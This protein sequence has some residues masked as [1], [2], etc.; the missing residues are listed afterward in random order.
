MQFIAMTPICLP[1]SPPPICYLTGKFISA[2]NLNHL[3][4]TKQIVSD[5]PDESDGVRCQCHVDV[6][7]TPPMM[8]PHHSARFQ[9][10][11]SVSPLY[12]GIQ[13]KPILQF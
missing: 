10:G 9:S 13:H 12:T 6:Q 5:V 8:A 7:T 11:E 1:L 2:A 3:Q 4:P